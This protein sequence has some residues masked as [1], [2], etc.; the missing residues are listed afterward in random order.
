MRP[1][2]ERNALA[3]R[4]RKT[5]ITSSFSQALDL[6]VDIGTLHALYTGGRC[7]CVTEIIAVE[8][9][10]AGERWTYRRKCC[11]LVKVGGLHRL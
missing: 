8:S 5:S 9:I 1:C 2:A 3:L 6:D 4:L 7:T 10:V 11:C